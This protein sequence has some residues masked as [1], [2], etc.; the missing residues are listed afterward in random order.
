MGWRERL[1]IKAIKHDVENIVQENK[2]DL[3]TYKRR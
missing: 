3:W 2:S 1:K